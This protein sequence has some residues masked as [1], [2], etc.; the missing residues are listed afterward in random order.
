MQKPEIQVTLLSLCPLCHW[1][2]PPPRKCFWAISHQLYPVLTAHSLPRS[3]SPFT[4][5]SQS[6]PSNSL[7]ILQL[8]SHTWIWSY[9]LKQVLWNLYV[10]VPMP[11]FQN[12]TAFGDSSFKEMTQWNEDMTAGLNPIWLESS[13]E[14]EICK[15]KEE[16]GAYPW[17]LRPQQEG[18]QAKEGCPYVY[19]SCNILT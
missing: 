6:L 8:Q 13:E 7:L 5:A 17:G 14:E 10:Q 1:T 2:L 9:E 15:V 12:G 18:S 16:P 19:S 3:Q 11:V 4:T